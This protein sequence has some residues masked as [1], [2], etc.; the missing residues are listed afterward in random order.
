[1]LGGEV[2]AHGAALAGRRVALL[3]RDLVVAAVVHPDLEDALDVHLDHVLAGQSVLLLEELGE[4]GVVE[5]LGAQQP[6]V[7][8]A[9]TADLADLAGLH[10]RRRRALAAHADE[11]DALGAALD[12]LVVGEGVPA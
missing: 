2:G 6:D 8:R 12:G 9:P 3:E 10:D 4:D 5:R 7:Q 1:M 11:R